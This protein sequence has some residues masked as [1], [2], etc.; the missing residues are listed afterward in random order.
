MHRSSPQRTLLALAGAG[1][2][3]LACGSSDTES[4]DASKAPAPSGELIE[5][6]SGEG[7]L[8]KDFPEDIPVPP[9]AEST[10]W[11]QAPGV[12][13]VAGFMADAPAEA[14]YDYYV[15]ELPGSGWKVTEQ[16][17]EAGQRLLVA[18]KGDRRLRISIAQVGK[19]TEIGLAISSTQR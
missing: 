10:R 14:T 18:D 4:G 7:N 13:T 1:L 6:E 17:Q 11:I 5:A 15:K 19:R 3:A 12:G 16:K 2:L 9:D 8:P